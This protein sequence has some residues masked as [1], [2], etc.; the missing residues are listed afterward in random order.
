MNIKLFNSFLFIILIFFAST[1]SVAQRQTGSIM[2]KVIEQD[3][4]PIPGATVTLNGSALMGEQIFVTSEGGDFRF[5][6]IPPGKDYSIKVELSGF[7]TVKRE[8]IVVHVGKTITLVI[9]LSME[10]LEEELVV[11]APTPTVDI[12]SS[13]ISVNYSENLFS[14]IPIN[15]DFYDVIVTAPGIISGEFEYHRDFVSHGG[16]I[17]SNQVAMDG[18]NITD[19]LAGTNRVGMP[20]DTFE[21]FELELGA[22]PAEVGMTEGAFVNIVTKSGG[23]TFHGGLNIY[24]FNEQMVKS[25]VPFEEAEAVGLE[26]PSG[27]KNWQDFS[28]TLGGP[29]LR[30]KLWFFINGRYMNRSLEGETLTEGL[31][32]IERKEIMTF[33]KLTFNIHPRVKLTGMWS[34]GNIDEPF[35]TGFGIDY[36]TSI[37]IFPS[38]NNA[39]NHAI[40]GLLNWIVNQNTFFDLRFNYFRQFDPWHFHSDLP[41]D[42]PTYIDLYTW[43]MSGAPYGNE[44]YTTER[45]QFTLSGTRFLDNFL[46]GNHELK[47]GLEYERAPSTW[48]CSREN[49]YWLYTYQGLPWGFYDISPDMGYFLAFTMGANKGDTVLTSRL[50]RFSFYI[51]DNYTIADRLTL[52]VGIRYDE[53]HGDILG[54]TF[55]P[56]GANDPVL[57]MLAPEIFKQ[58]DIKDTNNAIIWKDFS[59]RIGVVFDVFGD[60]STSIKASW[61]RYNEYLSMHLFNKMSPLYITYMSSL[62]IDLNLNGIIEPNDFFIPYYIPPNPTD[63]AIEE[64]L[65]PN[66]KSPYL[67]EFI[68]GLER[69][70]FKNFSLGISYIYK[71][72]QRIVDDVDKFRGYETDSGWWVPYTVN[73]PGWDGQYGT[74]D[75]SQITVYAVKNGAPESQLF[76]TNPQAAERKY[77]AVE[78]YL[79]KRMSDNWQLL[80][81]ITLSKFEGNIGANWKSTSGS[82]PIFNDPNSLINRYGRLD[83]DRPIQIKIQGSVILPLDFML[84]AFY[85][86]I[87]GTP[88]ARTLR[89]NFPSDPQFD[90]TNPTN[91]TINAEA[92]GERRYRAFNNLDLR[93]EKFFN[94]KNVGR[95]GVF[96]DV[97]NALGENWFNI[98]QDPGG[99]IYADGTFLKWPAY[100]DFTALNGLR[101]YKLSIRFTF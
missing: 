56:A 58:T 76:L 32:E 26:A 65:D 78:F 101:T 20:F 8:G 49:P 72:K 46:G 39:Q 9:K 89:I 57:T 33:A 25:I 88:W 23:N 4:S 43:V 96:L 50:R 38:I 90:P 81:S 83:Y 40:F 82:S 62:W 37:Y 45:I 66:L 59:P 47:V 10:K 79:N 70:I 2:G 75:D 64:N 31:V 99:T 91:V 14:N 87:S 93:I 42:L 61:S 94:I 36:Y 28:F 27:Y 24:Y 69:E 74:S 18:I 86:H 17:R 67:D 100:G 95:L 30:D 55:N 44:D 60:R 52:N 12:K 80:S 6:A 13:K 54:G 98:N 63:Y 34:F 3:N 51:Q 5:P 35:S 41:S 68:I 71:K 29:I 21:E 85:F 15:R 53:S 11:V 92:P 19:P 16:T 84:S 22:H 73:E 77:Q 48:D 1:F 97:L 7:Q